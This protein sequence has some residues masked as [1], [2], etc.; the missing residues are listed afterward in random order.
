MLINYFYQSN[1]RADIVSVNYEKPID[2][3]W[4]VVEN[5]QAVYIPWGLKRMRQVTI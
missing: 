3:N 5:D 1:L 4:D 2:T